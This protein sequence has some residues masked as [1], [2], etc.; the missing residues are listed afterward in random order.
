MRVLR[1]EV[2]NILRVSDL[3]LNMEGHHLVLIG[4]RNGQG[5]TSAIKALLM[6]LCGK[7]KMDFPEVALKEGEDEGWVKVDLS[8]DED[9]GDLKGYTIE[10]GYKRRRGGKIEESFRLLDSTGEE[11]PGPRELLESLF[12][13]RAF[14]PMGFEQAKPKER[15][16]L[17][18]KML[19][20][21]FTEQ[22]KEYQRIFTERTVANRQVK[23]LQARR[24]AVK[25]P[26]DAPELKVSV[27]S[28][29]AELD[30]ANKVNA[31]ADAKKQKADRA[32]VDAAR[33]QEYIARKKEDQKKL[34]DSID[35]AEKD[36]V[37]LMETANTLEQEAASANRVDTA[38]IK[39]QIDSAEELN[40]KHEAR[41]AAGRL[42]SEVRSATVKADSMTAQ[43][44]DITEAKR[45]S[46]EQ[47]KWPV[48]GMSLDEEGV[49][50][51]GLPFEQASRAQRIAASVRIGMAMNPKLR[52][53]VSQDGSD[54][55]LDTLKQLE[56]ICRE[57]DYQ[58]IMEL[59]TRGKD[60]E[61]LCAVVFEDGQAKE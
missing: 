10:L 5:K 7:R 39:Q 41:V 27:S 55:D 2:H 58:L 6:A 28:L 43:L 46:M 25:V 31:E 35:A 40:Q 18:R 47:A 48:P 61:G 24:A 42:D 36:L 34:Q 17:I 52:L 37:V 20:L 4:G 15:A 16:E 13:L 3:D 45:K 60:D 51:N 30:A 32:S 49:M 12:N 23:D 56:E 14:D 26:K 9:L 22:D 59:V 29:L 21:D 33:I 57:E 1:L 19:G 44:E 53:M 8:G 11:A 38:S 50:L 54:C